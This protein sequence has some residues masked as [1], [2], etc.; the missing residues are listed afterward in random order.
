MLLEWKCAN[1]DR[2]D[3]V[4]AVMSDYAITHVKDYLKKWINFTT[5][6][7]R[8]TVRTYLQE[9]GC[10]KESRLL[11]TLNLKAVITQNSNRRNWS[12]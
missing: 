12:S 5:H 11:T 10:P 2:V 1:P 9:M 6:D 3:K 4:F 8:R 7:L